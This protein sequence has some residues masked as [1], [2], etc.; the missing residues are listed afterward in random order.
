MDTPKIKVF[1]KKL[2]TN[3]SSRTRPIS[4]VYQVTILV[5]SLSIDWF[6]LGL[7]FFLLVIGLLAWFWFI[8]LET[9]KN[10]TKPIRL[11]NKF[12]FPFDL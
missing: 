8:T 1:S 7:G 2:K 9:N 11:T 5:G 4:P 12:I 3:K 10:R 6:G